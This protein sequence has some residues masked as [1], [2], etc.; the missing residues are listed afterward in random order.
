M[1]SS[2]TES[3]NSSMSWF[4]ILATVGGAA[5]VVNLCW[6]D[7]QSASSAVQ[8][9][10]AGR[11]KGSFKGIAKGLK[12]SLTDIQV[13]NTDAQQCTSQNKRQAKKARQDAQQPVEDVPPRMISLRPRRKKKPN[14][15]AHEDRMAN[16]GNIDSEKAHNSQTPGQCITPVQNE[17]KKHTQGN[18]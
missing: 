14:Y 12:R 18:A 16:A 6:D 1:S 13:E 11:I 17:R 5:T 3:T 8:Q 9:N 10:I 4:S 2:S 15:E 7:L